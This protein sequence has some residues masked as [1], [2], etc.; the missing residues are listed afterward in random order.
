MRHTVLHLQNF[1]GALEPQSPSSTTKGSWPKGLLQEDRQL[2]C[3]TGSIQPPLRPGKLTSDT[4]IRGEIYVLQRQITEPVI[5]AS[6]DESMKNCGEELDNFHWIHSPTHS[7]PESRHSPRS[8][9]RVNQS[10]RAS[11]QGRR[12]SHLAWQD[13]RCSP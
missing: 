2:T 1:C 7:L 5:E 4:L 9:P 8:L 12:S 11:E 13:S 10:A 6:Y 3:V